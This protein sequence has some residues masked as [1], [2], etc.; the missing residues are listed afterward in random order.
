MTMYFIGILIPSWIELAAESDHKLWGERVGEAEWVRMCQ[1]PWAWPSVVGI[2]GSGLE[3]ECA[4]YME[5]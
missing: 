5:R 4:L 3:L 2:Y 1:T